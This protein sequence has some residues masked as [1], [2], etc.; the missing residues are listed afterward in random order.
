[1]KLPKFMQPDTAI[2]KKYKGEGVNGPQYEDGIT[3][4]GYYEQ[5]REI[6]K[7][8]D[9]NEIISSS[10]FYTSEDIAIPT[11]SILIFNSI[12]DEVIKI[13]RHR[14]SLTGQLNHIE[15]LLK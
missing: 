3:I 10:K 6:V 2:I 12:E 8:D 7:D 9:G 14:S 15:V 13:D 11:Q 1:M 4:T 5:K